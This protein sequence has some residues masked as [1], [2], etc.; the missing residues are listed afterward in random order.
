LT[1]LRVVEEGGEGKVQLAALLSKPAKW[2]TSGEG[3]AKAALT[4]TEATTAKDENATI[5]T[6]IK[7]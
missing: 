5:L 1:N 2:S 7:L 6:V 3:I 4:K